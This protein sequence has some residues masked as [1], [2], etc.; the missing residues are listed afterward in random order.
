MWES[1]I[2]MTSQPE[3]AVP[4]LDVAE[5][6]KLA[7]AIFRELPSFTPALPVDPPASLAGLG[8]PSGGVPLGGVGL[9]APLPGSGFPDFA[10]NSLAWPAA[11]STGQLPGTAPMGPPFSLDNIPPL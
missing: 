2:S 11:P 7:G 5:L 8:P 1:T 3:L 6:A 9:T 10:P 4:P